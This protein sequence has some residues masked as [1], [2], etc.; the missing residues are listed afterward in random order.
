MT[1]LDA[2]L[3]GSFAIG[4]DL[5]VN[6][7]GF[8]AMR[9]TGKGIWGPPEDHDE[10]IRVLKRLPEL[11]VDFIDTA[12]SYGPYI[13]EDLI[14]EALSPRRRAAPATLPSVSKASSAMSRF[15]SGS[16]MSDPSMGRHGVWR[17]LSMQ[18]MRLSPCLAPRY[19]GVC[20]NAAGGPAA[21]PQR[22]FFRHGIVY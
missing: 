3:S 15:R 11:N 1:K 18:A 19:I 12:E 22:G 13:S 8:G 10:A 4:G 7:L 20:G 16:G 17:T 6:R 2:S 21:R 14:A 9:I 5:K